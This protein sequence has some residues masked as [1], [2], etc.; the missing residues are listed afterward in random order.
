[1]KRLSLY[2]LLFLGIFNCRVKAQLTISSDQ[3]FGGDFRH[4][5]EVKV[6]P[7][8]NSG[9]TTISPSNLQIGRLHIDPSQ[10]VLNQYQSQPNTLST[11]Q[12]HQIDFALPVGSIAGSYAVNQ[13]GGLSYT[14]P[15]ELPPGT[16]GMVPSVSLSYNAGSFSQL[17][18][19]GWGISGISVI[20][21]TGKDYYHETQAEGVMFDG[22]DGLEFNGTRMIP[23]QSLNNGVYALE[24]DDFTRIKYES[25]G[26]YY[27]VQ[28]KDGTTI[29][30][31][32]SA[33]SKLEII[34]PGTT[35][36]GTYSY[37]V[38]KVKDTYGNYIEYEYYTSHKDIRIKEIR[39]TGFTDNNGVQV[40]PYN[41]VRFHYNARP[42]PEK[43][44]LFGNLIERTEI[45][46]Q[47]EVLAEGQTVKTYDLT[48]SQD[49]MHDLLSEVVETG[50]DG[51]KLNST[52]VVYGSGTT[53]VMTNHT[54][55]D[56]TYADDATTG[57]VTCGDY[58]I[59]DF[60]GDGLSDIMAFTFEGCTVTVNSGARFYNGWLLYL[61]NGNGNFIPS[62]S[63]AY[64]PGTINA[65]GSFNYCTAW[66]QNPIGTQ[67]GDFNGDGKEDL[68]LGL[69]PTQTEDKYQL[70]IS[71][72]SNLSSHPA[73]P[74]LGVGVPIGS[75]LVFGDF[76]GDKRTEAIAIKNCGGCSAPQI[77]FLYYENG[78]LQKAIDPTSG[79]RFVNE[80]TGGVVSLDKYNG[81]SALDFDN[82]GIT[83]ISA[84][85]KDNH[86]VVIKVT[87]TVGPNYS[88]FPINNINQASFKLTEIYKA[89][90]PTSN[91]DNIHI[92]YGDYN[93]DGLPDKMNLGHTMNW[94]NHGTGTGYTNGAGNPITNFPTYYG[95]LN[96]QYMYLSADISG[97]G[98]SEVLFFDCTDGDLHV[99]A[100]FPAT[101][102]TINYGRISGVTF[103]LVKDYTNIVP[104]FIDPNSTPLVDANMDGIAGQ[105]NTNLSQIGEATDDARFADSYKNPE[106][107]VGDFNGDGYGDVMIKVGTNGDR[108]ILY[109]DPYDE[110]NLVTHV[111]DG[112]NNRTD[113]HYE[114][115][116][117]TQSTGFYTKGSGSVYPVMDMKSPYYA[118]ASVTEPD[119]VGGITQTT[120][121]YE[122][123]KVHLKGKGF[124]GFGKRITKNSTAGFQQIE[125]NKAPDAT[126]FLRLPDRS[127][128]I[129][130]SNSSLIKRTT[131]NF[132]ISPFTSG[133]NNISDTR[134]FTRNNGHT[135]F[136]AV[137]GVT[138]VQENFYDGS[139]PGGSPLP[140]T[141]GNV[142]FILENAGNNTVKTETTLDYIAGPWLSVAPGIESRLELIHKKTTRLLPSVQPDYSRTTQYTYYSTGD[143]KETIIEPGNAKSTTSTNF[144]YP[145]NGVLQQQNTSALNSQAPTLL[146]RSAT[147]DYDAKMRLP[148]KATQ[149]ANP[150][151]MITEAAYDFKFGVPTMSKAVDGLITLAAYDGFGRS[152]QVETPDHIVATQSIQ[153]YQPSSGID[154]PGD[155]HTISSGLPLFYTRSTRPGSPAQTAIFDIAGRNFKSQT[156]GFNND[157][158]NFTSYNNKGQAVSRVSDYVVGNTVNERL[159]TAYT[160]NDLFQP[161][162]ATESDEAGS[163]NHLTSI[164]YAYTNGNAVTTINSPDGKTVSRTMDPVGALV[165]ATDAGGIV[166]YKYGSH[167]NPISVEVNNNP[168]TTMVYDPVFG[169]QTQLFEVN[170]GTSLYEYDAY[171]QLFMQKDFRN[172]QFFYAYD[173]LGRIKNVTGPENYDYYY[174]NSGNGK[175]QLDRVT[176]QS[177][178]SEQ[179]FSYD[180]LA[181]PIKIDKIVDGVTFSTQYQYDNFS[182]L[183]LQIYPNGFGIKRD[184]DSKGYPTTIS[185]SDNGHMIWQA[186]E[187]ARPGMLNK[188]TLGNNVQ[189][190]KT[191]DAKGFLVTSQAGNLQNLLFNFDPKNG[192]LNFITDFLANN[193]AGLTEN[194]QYDTDGIALDRL[195]NWQV[196]GG[197]ANSIAYTSNSNGN[198]LSKTD[199]GAYT[200]G[201]KPHA[202]KTVDN[203]N[204]IIPSVQQDITYNSFNKTSTIIEGNNEVLI[205]YGPDQERTK[206]EVKVNGQT[207]STSYYLS[208]FEKQILPNGNIREV[209]YVNAP[210]GLCAMFVNDNGNKN[211]YYVYSDHLGSL[212][213]LVDDNGNT[214][215]QNFDPWGR[216]RN[217][218]T[219]D[220]ANVPATPA[221]LT[222]GY[223][224]HEYL[225]QFSLINMN[226][227]MYDPVVA[228]MLSPDN[229]VS[230]PTST[231]GYNRY[232][233]VLNNPL[234]YTDPTGN[235]RSGGGGR[236]LPGVYYTGANAILSPGQS[237]YSPTLSAMAAGRGWNH[238]QLGDPS[239]TREAMDETGAYTRVTTTTTQI[240]NCPTTYDPNATMEYTTSESH[241]EYS[242]DGQS[243]ATYTGTPKFG[244]GTKSIGAKQNLGVNP[245]FG[246]FPKYTANNASVVAIALP[247]AAPAVLSTAAL[248]TTIM[249]L[250]I[251]IPS[252]K[253]ITDRFSE[254]TYYH[255]STAKSI[256]NIVV[257]G[258]ILP[259]A[260]G[261]VYITPYQLSP[262]GAFYRLFLGQ[263]THSGK[264]DFFVKFKLRVRE[265]QELIFDPRHPY[266][267]MY[268]SGT[269]RIRVIGYGPN[270]FKTN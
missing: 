91:L 258:R 268:P 200:Y 253:P 111:L 2:L 137:R 224:G 77:T 177:N 248:A 222:R 72:G 52:L 243:A 182:N 54:I 133:N 223:T 153:W 79:A 166:D 270:F 121:R 247:R 242:I 245:L 97:D 197:V 172:N 46:R 40:A 206:M 211:L 240:C 140:I 152:L 202:V 105:I 238:T 136:D 74:P 128:T 204:G 145:N 36:L 50:A 102:K 256:A 120:Y 76:N 228:R 14:I 61:N 188:Y 189:T 75:T 123:A 180:G 3:L 56:F 103:P 212:N 70:Y 237:E 11:L 158:S 60:N 187:M 65:Y 160:Y 44:Y 26:D 37:F 193:G 144:Y 109:F 33:N 254:Q 138:D 174:V 66:G 198:I 49:N 116:S 207:T 146:T 67:N 257:E 96:Q 143:I 99:T 107:N 220:F 141:H 229:E 264:E 170:S 92:L 89:A 135:T 163:F 259:N 43:K 45:L 164:V 18:G 129:L 196:A 82:D 167:G 19:L 176:C 112:F 214:I 162:T 64:P 267:L 35:Q 106:F 29:E 149:L 221:W 230:D 232:S 215:K 41:S 236:S 55:T 69:S 261:K 13:N 181:R 25:A 80:I 161:L 251:V 83:D 255:Y 225:P 239:V 5:N 186:D 209:N 78:A 81:F 93:G 190:I 34:K 151:N 10:P 32:N 30:L 203:P 73:G 16:H 179:K 244:E 20:N 42:I 39:Y 185:R 47:I 150:N 114:P 68:F 171:G 9:S 269:L 17:A 22:F 226:G 235:R 115:L 250:P 62:D 86:E 58:R 53:G 130:L 127:S 94:L 165:K 101:G 142:T 48:Y 213:T 59:G 195:T 57:G 6:K 199:L 113:F 252:D 154:I 168:V 119:G 118:I 24:Y 241:M 183:A 217:P 125:E 132:S 191:F 246:N 173:E 262:I 98:I 184:Y 231:Q 15:I 157:I 208:E 21:R 88:F 124:L 218:N 110:Q 117:T 266:E 169:T 126:Y 219:W 7:N 84:L 12:N 265:E 63:K 108:L 260:K 249:A 205:N 31:G 178:G 8:T 156:Q 131:F 95:Y 87:G 28:T 71:D 201:A 263:K 38:S 147:Y 233:Y 134:I 155:P 194:Y 100:T 159:V 85:D 1:M 4:Q 192:N 148:V 216:P 27:V 104:A 210:Y 122:D 51:S 175:G 23:I 139:M 234:K 90:A 227:R